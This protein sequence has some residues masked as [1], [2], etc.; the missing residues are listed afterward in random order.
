MNSKR[1]NIKCYTKSQNTLLKMLHAWVCPLQDGNC[2]SCNRPAS[3]KLQS[4]KF[5]CKFKMK[6][7][8]QYFPFQNE[9]EVANIASSHP[10]ETCK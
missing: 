1:G 8:L 10:C 7:K 2:K 6:L 3:L 4:C 5:D 9:T